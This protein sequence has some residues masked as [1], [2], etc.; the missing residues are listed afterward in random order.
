MAPVVAN[1]ALYSSHPILLESDTLDGWSFNISKA[2]KRCYER[3]TN[4]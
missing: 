1:A 3:F 4:N 2:K